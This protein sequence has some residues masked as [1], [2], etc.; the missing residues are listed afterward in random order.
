MSPK[1]TRKRVRENA[2]ISD[3]NLN[4]RKKVEL[5]QPI[6]RLDFIKLAKKSGRTALLEIKGSNVAGP[7]ND[8][9]EKEVEGMLLS[10]PISG[11]GSTSASLSTPGSSPIEEPPK[12]SSPSVES[13][14]PSSS[15]SETSVDSEVIFE[16][17]SLFPSEYRSDIIRFPDRNNS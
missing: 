6:P 8:D 14:A 3:E 17:G 16:D 9:A 7:A 10:S 11:Q 1:R 12:S 5:E 4:P 2:I 15:M 13:P